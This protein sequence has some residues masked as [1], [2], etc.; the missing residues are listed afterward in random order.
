MK[1]VLLFL[2]FSSFCSFMNAEKEPCLV[3]SK[4]DKTEISVRLTEE[5]LITFSKDDPSEM[6]ITA[7]SAVINL[8]STDLNKMEVKEY[9]STSIDVVNAD[10]EAQMEYKGDVLVIKT[11]ASDAKLEVYS[12]NGFSVLT[13]K[14]TIGTNIVPLNTLPSGINIIKVND[15][16]LK[17]TRR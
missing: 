6:I 16:T 2:L 3:I 4:N 9:V 13:K 17:I 1:K 8:K 7:S 5:P 10:K 11:S 15:Q 14:L 12:V